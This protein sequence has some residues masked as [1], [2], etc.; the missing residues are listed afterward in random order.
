MY[1]NGDNVTYINSFEDE[2]IHKE[3]KKLI[4]NKII[5]ANIYRIQAYDSI[6]CGYVY[7][8]FIDFM[9]KGKTWQILRI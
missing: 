6:M 7:V 3:I 4:G 5:K 9:F 8:G 1:I 2:H